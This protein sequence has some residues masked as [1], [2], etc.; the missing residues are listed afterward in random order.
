M[1]D[2]PALILLHGFTNSGASWAPVI[3]GLGERYRAIAPDIR[4]H[5]SAGRI[6]PIT[7]EAVVADV[8][9]LTE[10]PFALA[11]YSQG[12]RIA[13]HVA[14]AHPE[15]VTRLVLLS[16]SPGLAEADER[17][18][19][20][21]SDARL[22]AEME[23]QTIEEFAS[24]WAET[25]V[26][27]DLP[28]ELAAGA[29]ADRLRSTPQD[30]AAALRGLGTGSL[31]SAWERL[32]ELRMPVSLIVGER[33]A[34]FTALAHEMARRIPQARV[35]VVPGAGHAVHL[36][37]PDVVVE[38]LLAADPPQSSSGHSSRS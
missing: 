24:R 38:E 21:L 9:A 7:L 23:G 5:A 33:D 15:R 32:P 25:T 16:A 22:A 29:H 34:K 17:E 27:A 26:L 14:L 10:G 18:R 3:S 13:L 2:P 31:P 12:G 1:D 20:R 19:R 37:R 6:R 4:G 30:L 8:A 36:E 11:G 35:T 28:R